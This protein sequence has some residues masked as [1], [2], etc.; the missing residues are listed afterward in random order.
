M[1][2]NA[3]KRFAISIL[4]TRLK[5]SDYKLLKFI[6]GE[7]TDEEYASTREERRAWRAK[8]NELE[9]ELEAE[10]ADG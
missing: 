5:S 7:L 9:A 10:K 1:D 6:E 8:I 3:N 4:K 2:K